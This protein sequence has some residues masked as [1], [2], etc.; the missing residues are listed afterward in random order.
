MNIS[1]KN[2]TI[3]HRL[4]ILLVLGYAFL[5]L[6]IGCLG[7]MQYSEIDSNAL[8]VISIQYRGS[9]TVNQ[10][11]IEQARQDFPDLYADVINYDNLRS[12]KL[13]FISEDEWF[14]YYFPIYPLCCIPVKLL[15]D[16][17]G[18]DQ[19]RC[20]FITNSLFVSGALM[21]LQLKLKTTSLRRL[22]AV[23]L[24]TI[25]PIIY[26][27]NYINYE[28]FIFAMLTIAMVLYYNGNR[29]LSALFTSIGAMSNSAVAAIGLVMIA[30]Y[31]ICILRV[32][33]NR[34]P[35]LVIKKYWKETVWYA[36]CFVPCLLPFAVQKYFLGTNT[37]SSVGTTENICSRVLTYLFDPTLGFT[38]FAPVP[39]VM[40]FAWV[41]I[42]VKQKKYQAITWCMMFL[43]VVFAY[44]LMPHIN[45]GMIFCARY[46]IW[47]YPII[48]VFLTTYGADCVRGRTAHI[49]LG[50]TIISSLVLMMI[51]PIHG[52]YE[53]SNTSKWL[54]KY[55]PAFYNQ[56]SA[57]FYCRTLHIDGAY[58]LTEPT[59]YK[60]S[61]TEQI[62]KLIY[63]ADAG[64]DKQIL[65]EIKG[66][67]ASIQYLEN[68][69]KEI[70]SDG[71]FHYI[72]FPV[73]GKYTIYEKNP[74]EAGEL[75][76]VEKVAEVSNVTMQSWAENLSGY[77]ISLSIH[78]NTYYQIELNFDEDMDASLYSNMYVD[79]YA[80]A[81]YDSAE[82]EKSG[83]LIEGKYEYVFYFNSGEFE[84]EN[85][86]INAR[87]FTNSDTPAKIS[88]FCITE[89]ESSQKDFTG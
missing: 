15:L 40:F 39:L 24:L 56:Y 10:A 6:L 8:P 28:A 23:L 67:E 83:F 49:A 74:I 82:Q 72:N 85:M 29:K 41:I 75:L 47:S 64:S 87:V 59:Y 58:D 68:K 9:L 5:L 52:S 27:N 62:Y 4:G 65:S 32:E 70:G 31:I 25:S 79:F 50:S 17:F 35:I 37:F 11:D 12:A 54:L 36:I 78:P 84:G 51:N 86:E 89:L 88:Y 57:T 33:W 48:P 46:V 66:D 73:W 7:P 38:L 18:L 30:E 2:E 14:P 69:L 55:A 20:F 53:Y 19:Q 1:K 80:G 34:S 81:L 44:S 71:K 3:F 26:Y 16:F 45:C 63:K 76:P 21:F 13:I 60:D 42:A 77:G 22:V 43:T 61:N